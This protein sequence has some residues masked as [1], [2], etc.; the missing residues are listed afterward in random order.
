MTPRTPAAIRAAVASDMAGVTA[1]YRASVLSTAASFEI[2]PPDADEMA[3][4][5]RVAIG[6]RCPYLVADIGGVVAGY[7]YA[8]P[9]HERAAFAWTV[10]DAIY[11]APEFE[12]RGIG[13]M[14]LTALVDASA[15]AGF[16]QMIA[17]I[18]TDAEANSVPLHLKLG[19]VHAGRITAVG[20]KNGRWHD[21]IY[22]QRSLGCG[23][24]EP[25]V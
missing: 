8:R 10:E 1:I 6:A 2:V 3:R 25:P 24:A 16:R 21:I 15:E 11:I 4:R 17:L 7:A 14:L 13:T 23:N 18:S 12:R 20:F 22:L 9:F 5:W 19:F